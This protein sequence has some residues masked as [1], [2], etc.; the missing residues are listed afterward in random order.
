MI[1]KVDYV[2]N[3]LAES[4]NNWIKHHKSLNLD[5]QVEPKEKRGKEVGWI[6]YAPHN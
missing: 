1:C 6:D 5:D 4:F 2:T 3:N